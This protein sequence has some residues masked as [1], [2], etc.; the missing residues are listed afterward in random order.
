MKKG[1]PE[2]KLLSL[3]SKVTTDWPVPQEYGYSL[4]Q[5]SL[6]CDGPQSTSEAVSMPKCLALRA[7]LT[8]S[9]RLAVCS[10]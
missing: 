8:S 9:L 4:V 7:T 5:G 3:S 1:V 6:G 10:L 2:E